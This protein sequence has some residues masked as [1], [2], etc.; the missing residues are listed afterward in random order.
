[1]RKRLWKNG[2][3][4]NLGENSQKFCKKFLEISGIR[5]NWGEKLLKLSIWREI[6]KK[7]VAEILKN[8]QKFLE[9]TVEI[10]KDEKFDGILRIYLLKKCIQ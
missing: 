8:F 7:I 3:Y 6:A 1:M 4:K 5:E 10:L 2:R 9:E